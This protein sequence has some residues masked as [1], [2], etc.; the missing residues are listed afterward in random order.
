MRWTSKELELGPLSESDRLAMTRHLLGSKS[1]KYND[2][3]LAKLS[4]AHRYLP[5]AINQTASY[6][7]ET[8]YTVNSY[9]QMYKD[10][11]QAQG[12]QATPA[13]GIR[14]YAK[15]IA[16]A[17]GLAHNRLEENARSMIE[18]L[19]FFDPDQIP[20][21]ML[22]D[23]TGRIPYL[24]GDISRQQ[25][26]RELR[27]FLMIIRNQESG[28]LA[29]HRLSRDAALRSLE[30]NAQNL[31]AAFNNAVHLISRAFPKQAA[32]RD[33][34]TEVW[35]KCETYVHHVIS[36]HNEF[37]RMNRNTT[38]HLSADFIDTLYNCS[39]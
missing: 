15:S 7:L 39:W 29:I 27:N 16:V 26:L 17:F 18:S 21:Q 35:N 32:S 38:L 10:R 6:I 22:C 8:D 25:I 19:A 13:A 11:E 23:H 2:G 33:H 31:E 36:L 30:T 34:M 3:E 24:S 20:E 28:T 4:E 5:L 9:L 14:G 37:K 12:L 1:R